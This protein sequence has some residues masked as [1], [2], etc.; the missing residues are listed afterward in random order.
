MVIGKLILA[1]LVGSALLATEVRSQ[2]GDSVPMYDPHAYCGD[3]R[4]PSQTVYEQCMNE[5]AKAY[6]IVRLRW[7]NIPKVIRNHC[8]EM[9]SFGPGTYWGLLGCIQ[10]E[11]EAQKEQM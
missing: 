7:E 3:V 1:G 10:A 4:K 6:I 2:K 8:T 9:T 5:E 11:L